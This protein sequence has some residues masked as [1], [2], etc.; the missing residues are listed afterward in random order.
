MRIIGLD[1]GQAH[2][3][4]SAAI[5]DRRDVEPPEFIGPPDPNFKP[6]VICRALRE[7]PLGTDYTDIIEDVLGI[8]ATVFCVDFGGV[9][10]P[11][12]DMLRK[13]AQQIGYKGRIK[14]IQTIGSNARAMQKHE[15]RGTHWNVPKVDLVTSIILC[16]QDGSLRL[17]ATAEVRKL[18]EQLRNFRMTFTKAANLQFGN[19]PGGHDDLISALGMCCWWC[20]RFGSMKPALWC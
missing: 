7:W 5:C 6:R 12:V 20:R 9:G 14:P 16:Q 10:R 13:R 18:L 17:P 2:D 8:P 4:A 15:A 3:P 19:A 11:V 1:L